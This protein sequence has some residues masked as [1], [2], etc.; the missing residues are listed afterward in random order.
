MDVRA[1]ARDISE[2]AAEAASPSSHNAAIAR[3]AVH[4]PALV[5]RFGSTLPRTVS[6]AAT[7]D[8]RVFHH[9]HHKLEGEGSSFSSSSSS[10][11]SSFPPPTY[12]GG[13]GGGKQA[14][15]PAA[16]IPSPAVEGAP[17]LGGPE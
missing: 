2:P 3:R 10:S 7:I 12:G 4:Q 8:G 15:Y 11:S 9:H 6:P 13:G 1:M 17:A 14:H 5:E 16:T